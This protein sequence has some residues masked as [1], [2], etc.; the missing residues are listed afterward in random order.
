MLPSRIQ[1]LL[2]RAE[3]QQKSASAESS[4][5]VCCER[6][7]DSN[8][9]AE[10]FF[11]ELKIKLR[12]VERWNDKAF[13]TGYKLFDADGNAA[14][15]KLAAGSDYI[16]ITLT[17]SGKSDWV[18]IKQ[19]ANAPDEMIL[20]VSPSP[21]PTVENAAENRT[22]HFFAPQATNN[23]CLQ[24]NDKTLKFYVIGLNETT[25][26]AET[27]NLL[28]TVRNLATANLGNLLGIQIAEWKIFCKNFL[29]NN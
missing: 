5:I 13:L 26:T 28:E 17:G 8:I 18:Q 15:D 21:D 20:T 27:A 19:I 23:F 25:N 7:L 2:A 1:D 11:A 29:E 4:S 14:P 10:T 9:A 22:S 12:T 16:R 24:K 6:E 3:A